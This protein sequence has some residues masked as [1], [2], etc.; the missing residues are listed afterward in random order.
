MRIGILGAG[1]LAAGLATVWLKAGHEVTIG[2]RSQG[3]A[4]ALAERL[5][6]GVRATSPKEAVAD[7]DVVLLAVSYEGVGEMLRSAGAEEGSLAGT[8]V[9]DATNAIGHGVGVLLTEPGTS[10]AEQVTDIAKGSRVVKA[11]HLFASTQWTAPREGES[12]VVAICGDDETALERT[13][14]LIRDVGGEP[15]VLGPLSRSRQLEEVAGFVIG[16]AFKGVD[17][18]RAMPRL[19]G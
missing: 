7:Q 14:Q 15:A 1:V 11:F 16:L 8:P 6:G 17:P 12:P 9:I 10:V 3:K 4:N 5:G 18:A 2:A 19:G 13:S